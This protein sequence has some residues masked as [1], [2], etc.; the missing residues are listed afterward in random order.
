MTSTTSYHLEILDDA[1][2][3]VSPGESGRVVM[4]DLHNTAMPFIRYDTGDLARYFVD[5][6]GVEHRDRITD[7][8]G[9]RLDVLLAG[10]TERP[11]KLHALQVWGPT[12]KIQELRQYQLR[13]H[14]IGRFTWIL[15]AQPSTDVEERLRTILTDVVG[16]VEQCDFTYVD[17]VP[18]MASGKRQFFV[19]EAHAGEPP[20]R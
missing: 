4:T 3:P 20:A 15:N 9:R 12:A 13:Q 17:E 1:D 5:D 8:K 16:P 11:I 10:S 6:K 2:T 14:A 18:V 19:N 7:I